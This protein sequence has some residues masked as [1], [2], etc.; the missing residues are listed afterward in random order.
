MKIRSSFLPYALPELTDNE[1]NAATEALK[2]LW[3]S[4]AAKT[5]QFEK[6]F[7]E[8]TGAKYALAVNSCTAALHLAQICSGISSDDEVITTPITFCSTV[9]TIIHCGAKPVLVDID[10]DTGLINADLIENAITNK[11]KA[12][13][14]VHYAGQA[15]D[16]DKI[17]DIAKRHNLIVIEDAAHALPTYY[18]GKIIGNGANAVAFSFYVT[19]N[20]STGEGGMLTT[21]DENLYNCAKVYSLHG[22]D[23]N[24][25]NRYM[26]GGS[27]C[28][29]V[30]FAGFKYNMTDI[31]ASLGIC[32]LDRIEQMQNKRNKYANLYNERFKSSE[33][34]SS[35]KINE[36]GKTS[37]HL[38]V[39]K[40]NLEKLKIAR[41][42]FILKL[43]E[44]NIGTSVH[45]KPI[46]H[47]SLYKNAF[48]CSL[49]NADRFY[50]RIISL[51]LYP[52]MNIEDVEYVA[53]AVCKIAKDNAK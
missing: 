47:H 36:Y 5:E 48:N 45:F 12:I 24:A 50:E 42:D 44:Y 17:N 40:L 26:Q 46:H 23:K 31:A 13:I 11:T 19:K 18:K 52:S 37:N 53:D 41:D 3:W 34:I 2:T 38:F 7:A 51:P 25:Y 27:H 28:Y 30:K 9:N 8:F 20:I 33:L 49:P 39:I 32:Q 4:R 1:I 29:D 22:M 15:C 6:K 16:M 43:A 14:P 21:N 35:L 10:Y